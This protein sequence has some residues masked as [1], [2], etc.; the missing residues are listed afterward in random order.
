MVSSPRTVRSYET[1]SILVADKSTLQGFA[2]FK[3]R[4]CVLLSTECPGFYRRSFLGFEIVI[5]ATEV[6]VFFHA[7]LSFLILIF[8]FTNFLSSCPGA[9]LSLFSFSLSLSSS[10][11]VSPYL[12]TSPSLFTFE[13]FCIFLSL[14]FSSAFYH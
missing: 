10:H 13:P 11:S 9:I 3:T 5:N 12:S 4:S 2:T 14:Y 8:S 1:F 7:F 6:A